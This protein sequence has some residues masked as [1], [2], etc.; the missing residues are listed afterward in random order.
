MTAAVLAPSTHRYVLF[1]DE[2]VKVFVHHVRPLKTAKSIFLLLER[3]HLP[4]AGQLMAEALRMSE[5]VEEVKTGKGPSGQAAH[6]TAT[7]IHLQEEKERGEAQD[8]ISGGPPTLIGLDENLL[9]SAKDGGLSTNNRDEEIVAVGRSKIAL[10]MRQRLPLVLTRDG[11][12]VVASYLKASAFDLSR[13][14]LR[15]CVAIKERHP[16]EAYQ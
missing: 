4:S 16:A 5:A 12:S 15:E 7:F 10:Q 14:G 6:E 11:A 9:P 8:V 3:Q 1:S 13:I 2:F